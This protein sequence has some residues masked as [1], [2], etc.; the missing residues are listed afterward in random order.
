[1]K[2]IKLPGKIGIR[3]ADDLYSACKAVL[4]NGPVCAFDFSRVDLIDLSVGQMV[5]A[6]GRE[7]GRRGGRLEIRNTNEATS[8]QLRLVGVVLEGALMPKGD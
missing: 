4:E 7:C 8:R 5:L 2:V 1:M 6:L 3:K